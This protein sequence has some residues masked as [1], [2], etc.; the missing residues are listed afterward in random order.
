MLLPQLPRLLPRATQLQPLLQPL[1]LADPAALAVAYCS[2]DAGAA[3][4]AA[5]METLLQRHLPLLLLVR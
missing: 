4:T 1:P 2:G 5:T 3:G